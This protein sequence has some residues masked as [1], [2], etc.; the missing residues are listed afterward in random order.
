MSRASLGEKKTS[1]QAHPEQC[2]H[3][4]TQF[5]ITYGTDGL[6]FD[7]FLSCLASHHEISTLQHMFDVQR[8]TAQ[9][10]LKG[11]IGSGL[12]CSSL[13]ALLFSLSLFSP[14]PFFNLLI[15]SIITFP[16]RARVAVA[17]GREATRIFRGGP[18]S[19]GRRGR[20][21][22]P[23]GSVLLER[24]RSSHTCHKCGKALTRYTL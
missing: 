8:S 13:S 19:A 14:S 4:R 22:A 1:S 21:V 12:R 17:C 7:I 23:A 15:L 3:A 18:F 11:S 10:G 24:R 20:Q 16:Y 2:T 6:R 5:Q 9:G